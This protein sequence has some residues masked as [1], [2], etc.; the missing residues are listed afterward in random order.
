MVEYHY[1]I[2]NVYFTN[3][4]S[5]S[6]YEIYVSLSTNKTRKKFYLEYRIDTDKPSQK[7]VFDDITSAVQFYNIIVSRAI[8]EYDCTIV[9]VNHM[10]F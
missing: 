5:K 3:S 9:N 8:N 4:E 7:M 2:Q 6:M 1:L 10:N